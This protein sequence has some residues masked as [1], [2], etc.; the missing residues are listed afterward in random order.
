MF[1][2]NSV[3]LKDHME[4]YKKVAQSIESTTN[5]PVVVT[6]MVGRP[7]EVLGDESFKWK[8]LEQPDYLIQKVQ[9]YPYVY[10]DGH[11]VSF[12]T[13]LIDP[14]TEWA[15][16]VMITSTTPMD[17]REW[18]D[19][20]SDADIAQHNPSIPGARLHPLTPGDNY[21]TLEREE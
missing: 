18:L 4:H 8:L 3:L 17:A 13:V 6:V 10:Q 9:R 1:D 12:I 15:N 2:P 16:G 5:Q 7:E 21:G 14:E 20:V 19:K 11:Q